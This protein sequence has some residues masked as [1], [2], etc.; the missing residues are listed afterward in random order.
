[1]VKVTAGDI[2]SVAYMNHHLKKKTLHKFAFQRLTCALLTARTSSDASFTRK[3]TTVPVNPDFQVLSVI[4]IVMTVAQI[5]VS[6]E[7]VST[8]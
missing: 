3:N 7:S 4:L 6:M 5:H 8:A 2:F 1:M